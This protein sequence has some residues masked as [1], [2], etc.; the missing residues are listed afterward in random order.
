MK[1]PHLHA[2]LFFLSLTF[3]PVSGQWVNTEGPEISGAIYSLILHGTDLYAGAYP[4][5]ADFSGWYG[6]GVF[7]IAENGSSS[8]VAKGMEGHYVLSLVAYGNKLF[9]GLDSGLY[10]SS[11]NG[12]SWERSSL[13]NKPVSSLTVNEN[14]IF[15]GT[16]S[17]VFRSADS[18]STWNCVGQKN[19]WI[20]VLH[21]TDETIFSGSHNGLFSSS[22]D[23]GITW[24]SV[25]TGSPHGSIRTITAIGNELFVGTEMTSSSDTGGV[26]RSVKTD[27]TWT[28]WSS[29]N[30]ELSAFYAI[31]SLAGYNGWIFAGTADGLYISKDSGMSWSNTGLTGSIRSLCTGNG[32][33]FAGRVVNLNSECVVWRRPLSDFEDSTHN[34]VSPKKPVAQPIFN[35]FSHTGSLT[36]TLSSAGFVRFGLYTLSGRAIAAAK[37]EYQQAGIHHIKLRGHQRLSGWYTVS[38]ATNGYTV[39]RRVFLDH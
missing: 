35:M 12:M 25:A 22:G 15:A 39:N 19:K 18:G 10:C 37:K 33:I 16:D 26:F 30:P 3:Y 8:W 14:F 6:G 28:P 23:N 29:M 20:V 2:S 24:S 9:A 21:A 13:H 17:G 36:Y 4:T 38:L 34:L 5:M 7:S 27:S 11:D 32:F 31:N 1:T